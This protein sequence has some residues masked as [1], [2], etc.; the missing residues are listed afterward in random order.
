VTVST[1]PL[2]AILDLRDAYRREMNCQIVHDSWHARRF[3]TP[4]LLHIEGE[5]VGYGAVGGAPG[6]TK[7]IVK[8]FYVRP[9]SRS[10]ALPL[11]RELMAASGARRVEAQTNDVLLSLMLFDCAAEVTT[12]VILFADSIA[13]RLSCPPGATLR[14]VTDADRG[15]VFTHTVEPVGDWGLECEGEL[16]ATGGLLFHYNPPYGD[17]Y[18]EVAPAHRRK[19]FGSYL[20]QE[21]KRICYAMGC[22]PAARCHQ[23]NAASRQTLE[24][25]GMFPCAR[26]LRGRLDPAR[27]S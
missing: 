18:M 19:R 8:E 1:A 4:Y 27:R 13:T 21:L 22:V 12:D 9:E 24:R 20:V 14:P 3:T 17:I 25:A 11:F 5:V 6:D 26:I 2:D 15:R 10:A 23:T 16:A 7:D